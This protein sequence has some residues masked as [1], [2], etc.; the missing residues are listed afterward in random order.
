MTSENSNGSCLPVS[1]I[2]KLRG[3]E[4][5]RAWKFQ[6][7]NSLKYEGLWICVTGF[8]ADDKTP[9][10]QKARKEEK[11]LSKINL[12]IDKCV[13][14]HVESATT[15]KIAWESLQQ[16][17]DGVG[18]YTSLSLLRQLCTLRLD[19]YNSTEEYVNE[20]M[21]ISIKLKEINEPVADKTKPGKLRMVIITPLMKLANQQCIRMVT[22]KNLTALVAK[23]QLT[24]PVNAVVPLITEITVLLRQRK[25]PTLFLATNLRHAESPSVASE[26]STIETLRHD[27]VNPK[28]VI[29]PEPVPGGS[30][31]PSGSSHSP[32]DGS[33]EDDNLDETLRPISPISEDSDASQYEE[34]E[35]IPGIPTIE[36]SSESEASLK[37]N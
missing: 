37:L 29:V 17:F 31:T 36:L 14:P 27:E 24:G 7:T 21:S 25:K 28:D 8:P 2:E 4:N 30:Q 6:M 1:V 18:L 34:A 23:H 33:E 20:A 32:D 16:A 3:S 22:A 26:M 13:Y 19:K 12:S 10:D 15:A 9:A 5:Y 35:N 11:A